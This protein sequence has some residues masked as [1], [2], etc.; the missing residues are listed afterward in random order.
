MISYGIDVNAPDETGRTPIFYA[1]DNADL[2]ITKLLLT[3]KANV[4][5]NLNLLNIAGKKY[6]R[7]IVQVF[8]QLCAE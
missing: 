5:N 7:E 2:K 1:T 6:C 3:H 8:L 4:K